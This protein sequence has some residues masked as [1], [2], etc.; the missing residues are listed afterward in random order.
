MF[1]NFQWATTLADRIGETPGNGVAVTTMTTTQSSTTR[2]ALASR[3]R[4]QVW[5]IAILMYLLRAACGYY[6]A[7]AWLM[8]ALVDGDTGL[9]RPQTD[10]QYHQIVWLPDY[11]GTVVS[12]PQ[13]RADRNGRGRGASD[14]GSATVRARLRSLSLRLSFPNKQA[15]CRLRHWLTRPNQISYCHFP[16]PRR[17][18]FPC[19]MQVVG[20]VVLLS[21]LSSRC[22]R[23]CMDN[24]LIYL[25]N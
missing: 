7:C 6:V 4:I 12:S 24:C 17:R 2:T 25:T 13:K 15:F 22:Q 18:Q 3:V 8:S 23:R 16:S 10:R 19:V 14:A 9:V 21:S 5:L 11:E 20:F 1:V